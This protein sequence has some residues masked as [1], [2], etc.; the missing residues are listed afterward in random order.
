MDYLSQFDL[1]FR[2]VRGANNEVADALSRIEI[3]SL[4][5]PSGIDY[6]ELA[7][8]QKHEGIRSHGIPNLITLPFGDNTLVICDRST[9]VPRP[10]VPVSLRRKIFE[11]MHGRA[12]PGIQSPIRLIMERFA[13][14]GLQKDIRE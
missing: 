1:E 4:Q 5:F 3:I 13:W 9:G 14:D 11:N 8:Q 7:A 10:V 12:H 6:T 2:H